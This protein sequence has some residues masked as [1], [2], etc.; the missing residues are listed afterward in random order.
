MKNKMCSSLKRFLAL[1]LSVIIAF[2]NI[3]WQT[4]AEGVTDHYSNYLDGWKVDVAWS[5]LSTDYEW[6]AAGDSTRQPKI[7]VT[8]RI[9]N[10][11]KDYPAGSMHFAIPGIGNASRN[12]T[13]KASKLAADRSDSEWS[14]DWDQGNDLYT[15]TNQFDVKTG[16]SVSGG[17]ELMWNF[18]ARNCAN[19]FAQ[20]KSPYFSIDGD[21]SIV[22]EPLSYKFT[23]AKD[24]YRIYLSKENITGEQ[25]ENA[26]QNY[27]WYDFTTR[28]DKD[29]LSRGVYK[30][31]YFVSLDLPDEA[32]TSDVMVL[33][34][35]KTLTLTRNEDGETGFYPFKEQYGGP[36]TYQYF[37]IGFKKTAL[38]GKQVTVHGHLDRMY[39][40]ES[41]WT[42]SA[43]S[44]EIV[45]AEQTFTVTSYSFIHEGYTYGIDSKNT[46]ERFDHTNPNN[47]ADRLPATNLYNGKIID[48]TISGKSQRKYTA[49]QRRRAARKM[50]ATAS[51]ADMMSLEDISVGDMELSDWD[52]LNWNENGLYEPEELNGMTYGDLYADAT[53]DPELRDIDIEAEDTTQPET[54]NSSKSETDETQE[55]E[56]EKGE[57][58]A[59]EETKENAKE[60][61]EVTTEETVK[62]TENVDS[63]AKEDSSSD[64]AESKDEKSNAAAME[65]EE[66]K[67][68]IKET[69]NKTEMVGKAKNADETT[70]KTRHPIS[71]VFSKLLK[72]VPADLFSL[73]SY[74]SNIATPS[75]T[76]DKDA[77][78][79][80]VA[81]ENATKT[82]QIGADQEY[83]LIIGD[84][85]LAVTLNDGS[86]RT[87]EPDEYDIAYV[88]IPNTSKSYGYEIFG[89]SGD[90]DE[91]P[92]DSYVLISSG[93]TGSYT[94][95]QLPAGIKAVF[96]RVNGIT[97]SYDYKIN[98]GIRF[99]LD[100]NEEQEKTEEEQ[101]DRE[102]AVVNFSYL[103]SVYVD[104]DNEEE[105]NDC[106]QEAG[107]YEGAFGEELSERDQS[108]YG[109]RLMRDYTN[110]WLRNPVLTLNAS[111]LVPAMEGNGKT[112]FKTSITST[113]TLQS[114]NHGE[115]KRFSLYTEV[116]DG[117]TVDLDEEGV[118]VTGSAADLNGNEVTNFGDYMTA[119]TREVNDKTVVVCDFDFSD[120]P[121][122]ISK[123]TTAEMTFNVYLAYADY[124]VYGTHYSTAAYLMPHD[125]GLDKVGGYSI[126]A[127]EYDLDEDGRTDNKMA[128]ACG[129][130]NVQDNATEWREFVSKY[131]KSYYSNGYV[132]DT[133][134]RLY[135]S[136]DTKE[137][138]E[139]SDYSYRLDFGLGSSNAKNII[140]FD[141]IEQGAKIEETDGDG[142]SNY[143]NISSA[144]QGTFVSVD[145]SAVKKLGLVPT[146]Y[147]SEDAS[148]EFDLTA[149][150]W[151]TTQPEQ[152]KSIAIALDT[153]Q[154]TDG[155]MKTQQMAYVT[156]NMQAPADRPTIDKKAVNQYTVQYDA[157]G[158]TSGFEK[159]YTLPSAET[160]VKCLD[161]VGKLILQ[162]VDADN[163]Q[164]TDEDGT[165]HYTSLTGGKVQIY[166]PDGT[167]LFENGGKELNVL[168]RVIL[169]N[170]RGGEYSWE[171]VQ[172]PAGYQKLS[173]KH[174]FTITDIPETVL[175]ENH[176]IPGSMTLTQRDA[177]DET[178]A[179]LANAKYQLFKAD[180]TQIFLTEE[181]G[182]YAYSESG[183]KD[184]FMTG[185]NG[186]VTI[187]NLPWGSYYAQE[188]EAAAGYELN[189]KQLSFE[190]GKAQYHADSDTVST[191]L[192]AKDT[193][194]PASICLTKTDAEDGKVLK[195]AYYDVA[196]RKPDSTYQ[197]L[198]E[199]LKTNAAG[200]LTVEGLK[201]GHYRFTEVIPPAGYALAADPV[202]ADLDETTA[203]TVVTISQTDDRK[204]G[205]ARLK[206]NSTDGMPLS[207]AEFALYKKEETTDPEENAN[208]DTLV[209]ERLVTE[210][211]GTTGAVEQLA[212]GTYYFLETKPPQG[213]EMSTEKHTFTVDASNAGSVQTIQV[214][215]EKIKGSVALTKMDEATKTKK[216]PDAQFNLYKND[217]SLIKEGLTTDGNGT[218]TV[219]DL[220]WGS[221][222]FE[223]MKAPAGYGISRDKVRFSVNEANCTTTQALT[224]YD[225]AEQVQITIRK[226]IN[227]WYEPFGN[228]TFLFEITGT[229]VNGMAHTW[230]KS[231][232]LVNG[233][234]TGSTILSGIPAGTYVIRE[235]G[236]ERYKL[237]SVTAGPNVTVSGDTA[238]AVLASAKEAEV[239]FANSISQYEK[240]SHTGNATNVVNAKTK[241]TGL[242]VTYKG[243]ATIESE[244]E[245]SY[246]FTADDLEAVAFY[247]DGS[248]KAIAFSDLELDSATVTGNNNSSGAGYTVNVSYTENGMTVSGSFSVEVN[249]QIPPQPF[250]VTY[251]ANGGYFGDDTS[252]TLNQVTYV[253]GDKARV[254][255][256]AKTDNVGEDGTQTSGSYGNNVAK[257]Q[258]VTIPGAESLKVTITYRTESTSYDWVCL[259]EGLDVTPDRYNYSQSK[260]GK[261]GGTTKT[262]KEFTIQG[263]TVQIF[264]RSDGSGSNYYG[265]YAVVEAEVQKTEVVAGK[266]KQPDHVMKT[267]A[268][269][270]TNAACSDGKEFTLQNCTESTIVY[271][272][273]KDPTAV[274]LD[275]GYNTGL[276]KKFADIAETPE[277]ITAFQRS[278]IMPD[279]NVTNEAHCIST[280]NSEVPVY[281]WKD[282][283]TLKWW[284]KAVKPEAQSLTYLYNGYSDLTDIS[285]L[286]G[287]D[288]SNVTDMGG[289]FYGC[290]NLTNLSALSGWDTSKATNMYAMFSGCESLTGLT[291]LSGW[292]T[293]RVTN[294]DS[295][296][297]SCSSLTGLT[298]LS[299]WNTQKV[300]NM[301][302]MFCSCR[303]L[304]NLTALSN[305]NTQK[306]T[307][308][309]AMFWRCRSLA[310]L[311]ALSGWDTSKV[312]NMSLMFSECKSLADLTALSGWN[313]SNVTNMGGMFYNC[314][315]LTNLTAL[316]NWDTSNVTD[317]STMFSSCESLTDL[318]AL[319]GWDTSKVT[320]MYAMFS[321][322]ESLTDL[323][324]LSGWN[325]SRVTSMDH[326]FA[327][328]RN[329]TNSSAINDWDILKVTNF[330][331]MF[332]SCS[333]HPEFTKRSGTWNDG[334]F[335]PTS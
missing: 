238:T 2:T 163:I 76:D 152:V 72:A 316:S 118:E 185:S 13:A 220:E 59:T 221:Y 179:P 150:G 121:L 202:E 297:D 182:M 56:T 196:V 303:S 282:G 276:S 310:D 199:Y 84:D 166:D 47:Y 154:M 296:F 107:S 33:Q 108:L 18:N 127:D 44:N 27:V 65:S 198:Y 299:N 169:N 78:A 48:F 312:T 311:T 278:A 73:T 335:T 293:S 248:S 172:A 89:T 178:H 155:V 105:V 326:M 304:A 195:D 158:L 14:Y 126:R 9:E 164:K 243:P 193:E 259:Y 61:A 86:M 36:E 25:Y 10:A 213:Y 82:S 12:S 29:V 46:Y 159:T 308:M 274:L 192:E 75:D 41:T 71:S 115:L 216:L 327:F 286:S 300:T 43:A 211:D 110:V 228:A 96:V 11:E 262:T 283:T 331:Y 20:T 109:E 222:Y 249:L 233:A 188:T 157:Y 183:T 194:L 271:A 314:S 112:G 235:R 77:T 180:G 15:F 79:F 161:N 143:K 32:K 333:S 325:T 136:K 321:G 206:K 263:E 168:G 135:D 167:A 174:T 50:V 250:T 153:S 269:W 7:V 8:Y 203:G 334:T 162:S 69:E 208:A 218:I 301:D 111:M 114:D 270:Y 285:G 54:S 287:Y 28:F 34:G 98:V 190:V 254:T 264:F 251:D 292:N 92:L 88:L 309:S 42:K 210:E 323:S 201:F 57:K 103:R 329:L 1:C 237:D 117:M 306:V 142:N 123:L 5:T 93:T 60:T 130:I 132:D 40:D 138:K 258:V 81:S 99:H 16:Q 165:V 170:I 67:E 302:S 104:E 247:D 26:D 239:T 241:L 70:V 204:T 122:D 272:K 49:S 106:A 141:N 230:N 275:S 125:E 280:E 265:F 144:W 31:T 267:F 294:M 205:S 279:A 305:W 298:A 181:N 100:W 64:K 184:S 253:M 35:K 291:A 290:G 214:S 256:V 330:T 217:G 255:K 94:A 39:Q 284:S 260:S 328:C 90:P 295:M 128:Y 151:T 91:T 234:T 268:G 191:T 124:T 74:A 139:K 6:N 140:F 146:V 45:D 244:T 101:V 318:S 116:P 4:F 173:G 219:T 23:S 68:K 257:N 156:V 261:L 17:F 129:S 171:M 332:V 30:S 324:A 277:T 83:S 215:N 245:N 55:S 113:G 223:E 322:C 38:D 85:K 120:S 37:S 149:S 175:I 252:S 187:S 133:V 232:T 207:G 319:S 288:T 225:P 119:T 145:T 242:Q 320:N 51:D 80:T 66:G 226:E 240:F 102:K 227:E 147:Y 236:T 19:G 200:E 231:I 289:M 24:R 281:L 229:D 177:D 52:D 273:W 95:K 3:Q 148:Q 97:G 63:T 212:W 58:D 315:S 189:T 53:A 313:A 197:K 176:R 307:N 87:L 22:M 131:V 62:E 246:T 209:K 137:N 21:G 317:M 160:Y 186:T 134:T 224:C 266:E